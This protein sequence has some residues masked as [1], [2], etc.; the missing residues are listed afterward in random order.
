MKTMLRFVGK[1]CYGIGYL[2]G[3]AK[4]WIAWYYPRK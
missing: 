2:V 4:W 3:S 1:A